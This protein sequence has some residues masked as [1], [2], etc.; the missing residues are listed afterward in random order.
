MTPEHPADS[1]RLAVDGIG[2]DDWS[3]AVRADFADHAR[4]TTIGSTL[5]SVDRRVQVWRINL[6]PGERLGA[7]RHTVEY[8]WTALTAGRGVQH[9]DDSST[10]FVTYAPGDTCH[11]DLGPGEYLLHDLEN[12]G[13]TPFAFVSVQFRFGGHHSDPIRAT[14]TRGHL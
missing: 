11:V 13:E 3:D 9:A 6:E 10:R 4:N 8:F 7:H 1:G 12:I 14:A 2:F 5:L